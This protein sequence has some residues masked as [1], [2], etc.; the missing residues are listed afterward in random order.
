MES[1]VF[2]LLVTCYVTYILRKNA[3]GESTFAKKKSSTSINN[4]PQPIEEMFK[5]EN[6]RT[7]Q[8]IEKKRET[9]LDGITLKTEYSEFEIPLESPENLSQMMKTSSDFLKTKCPRFVISN[10]MIDLCFNEINNKNIYI[11]KTIVIF[12]IFQCC[13]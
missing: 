3:F 6:I 4:T 7:A 11:E 1:R 8:S 10:Y 9:K 2:W 12:V 5:T 13:L